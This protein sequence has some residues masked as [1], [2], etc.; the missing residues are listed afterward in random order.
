MRILFEVIAAEVIAHDDV[1]GEFFVRDGAIYYRHVSDST[2]WFANRDLEDFRRCVMAF[3]RYCENVVI[4]A[5]QHTVIRNF[6]QDL[7][8][9][10]GLVSAKSSYWQIIL[11]QCNDGLL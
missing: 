1:G 9:E 5:D 7:T 11:E 4:A 8:A 6:E 10:R 3:D 2:I